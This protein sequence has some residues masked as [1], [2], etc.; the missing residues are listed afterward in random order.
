MYAHGISDLKFEP[1]TKFV[2][3]K[4]IIKPRSLKF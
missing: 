1:I 3:D 4:S 2:K